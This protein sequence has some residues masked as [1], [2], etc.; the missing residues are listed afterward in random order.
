[1]FRCVE[2]EHFLQ[3]LTVQKPLIICIIE[4]LIVKEL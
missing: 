4:Y 1:M 3:A 2:E